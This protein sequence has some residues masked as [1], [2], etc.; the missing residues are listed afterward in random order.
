MT[1]AVQDD[2]D[3]VWPD[4]EH[5]FAADNLSP[6]ERPASQ[7]SDRGTGGIDHLADNNTASF[8]E[9]AAESFDANEYW[10]HDDRTQDKGNLR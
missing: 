8:G 7:S 5:L 3:I 10:D 1:Q 4:E 2:N 9:M 6:N